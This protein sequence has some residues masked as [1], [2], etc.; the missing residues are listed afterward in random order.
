VASC[1][2]GDGFR[3][4]QIDLGAPGE[5]G[6][7]AASLDRLIAPQCRCLVRISEQSDRSFRGNPISCFG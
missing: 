2:P 6:A 1:T 3:T 5:G 7:W 4:S